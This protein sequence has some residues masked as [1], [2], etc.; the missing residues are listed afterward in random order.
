MWVL[1]GVEN[2]FQ[3]QSNWFYYLKHLAHNQLWKTTLQQNF[4]VG[5]RRQEK[6]KQKTNQVFIFNEMFN[7]VCLI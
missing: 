3:K 5:F 1:S 4:I 6:N 2:Q 7:V